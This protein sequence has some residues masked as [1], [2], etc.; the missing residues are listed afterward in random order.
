MNNSL[1]VLV[2]LVCAA[3]ELAI[4]AGAAPTNSLTAFRQQFD[5][6]IS[7][8]GTAYVQQTADK[9]G[10]YLKSIEALEAER[11]QAG[12]LEAVVALR[13]ARLQ[14]RAT[15][16]VVMGDAQAEL[17]FKERPM[18]RLDPGDALDPDPA[19]V[20]NDARSGRRR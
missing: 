16:N 14:F 18:H 4:A 8:A 9:P 13:Q 11:R 17:P 1:N 2:L 20:R 3:T 10:Q 5:Q 6:A 19:S 7:A 15:T 12:D